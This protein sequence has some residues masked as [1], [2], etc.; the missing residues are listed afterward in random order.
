[1]NS[2]QQGLIEQL[3]ATQGTFDMVGIVGEITK[4]KDNA[5]VAAML[6]VFEQME[7]S[8]RSTAIENS[9]SGLFETT[10]DSLEPLLESI[11]Q[12]PESGVAQAGSYI[13]GEIAYRQG[14]NRDPRI[15]PALLAGLE[16]SLP[17]G[18]DATSK[19]IAGIR[20]CARVGAVPEANELMLAV[21][22]SADRPQAK[23]N[24]FYLDLALAV[25][26][27]NATGDP[28]NFQSAQRAQ[29]A[30]LPETSYAFRELSQLLDEQESQ[31]P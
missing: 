30:R 12:A 26:A 19:Y 29:V 8:S 23:F 20:E 16:K 1:M 4:S 31:Q 28:E 11:T 24:N 3:L 15:L 6:D 7:P 10:P 25:L 27:I 13:L 5:L 17:L 14:R 18:I 9:V 2:A 22:L 21:L